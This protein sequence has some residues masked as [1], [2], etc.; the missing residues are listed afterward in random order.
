MGPEADRHQI[1]EVVLERRVSPGVS[2]KVDSE[3]R[4]SRTGHDCFFFFSKWDLSVLNYRKN[5]SMSQR[6]VLFEVFLSK[7]RE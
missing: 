5:N 7:I 6:V 1:L 3:Q 4:E 2:E